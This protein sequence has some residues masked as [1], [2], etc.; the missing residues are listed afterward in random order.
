LTKIEGL[1]VREVPVST[2]QFNINKTSS[3]VDLTLLLG[4]LDLFSSQVAEFSVDTS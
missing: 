3:V 1:N 2:T 4:S